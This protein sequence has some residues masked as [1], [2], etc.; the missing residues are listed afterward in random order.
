MIVS[1]ALSQTFSL[2]VELHQGHR[3]FL[4][5]LVIFSGGMSECS[6]AEEAEGWCQHLQVWGSLLENDG[7]FLSFLSH[8]PKRWSVSGFYWES[9]AWGGPLNWCGINNKILAFCSEQRMEPYDEASIVLLTYGHG[10]WIVSERAQM[11]IKTA[12]LLSLML[13]QGS[14]V[15]HWH[16]RLKQLPMRAKDT[17]VDWVVNTLEDYIG[18]KNEEHPLGNNHQIT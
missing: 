13:H 2:G 11:W 6:W 10:L 9:G 15:K 5:L 3:S 8:F 16:Q 4:I 17:A 14:R 18:N 12:E 1:L 7:S